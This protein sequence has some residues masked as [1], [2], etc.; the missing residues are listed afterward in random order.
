MLPIDVFKY[1]TIILFAAYVSIYVFT[2][3]TYITNLI[4]MIDYLQKTLYSAEK[5]IGQIRGQLIEVRKHM[6]DINTET[7]GHINDIRKHIQNANDAIMG[8]T[9][10]Q[11]RETV[12]N[13]NRINEI[14]EC[15]DVLDDRL[16][17]V[18]KIV[19]KKETR[20]A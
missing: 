6:Q 3:I 10:D 18:V 13:A 14:Y 16:L 7:I 11:N 20:N 8:Q 12:N 2:T 5:N 17:E 19:R 15:L 4:Y 1:I 9:I